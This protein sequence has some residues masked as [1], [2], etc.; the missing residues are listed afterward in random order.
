[1]KIAIV[2]SDFTSAGGIERV[3]TNLSN[4]LVENKYDLTIISLFKTN[5]NAVYQLDS[6]VKLHYLTNKNYLTNKIGGINRLLLYLKTVNK[7]KYFVKEEK[8]DFIIGQGFPINF[9]IFLAGLSNK[10]IACEHVHYNYYSSTIQKVRLFIYQKFSQVVVL[11]D[12][13]KLDF[14]SKGLINITMIPNIVVFEAEMS[15]LSNKIIISVGR[16]EYQKG[17]DILLKSVKE[18]FKKYPDWRLHIYG[19][20]LLERDLK[21]LLTNLELTNNVKF[22]GVT[23]NIKDAYSKASL[24]VMS[25]RFEG[26]GMVLVEAASCGLP[27]I[28][29]D[30]PNG[31]SDILKNN[32][33]ILVPNGDIDML[34][35]E[36]MEML[37]HPEKRKE[38]SSRS[39]EISFE[40]SPKQI[41]S[42]WK[43][44][45]L[46]IKSDVK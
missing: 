16:L 21:T 19:Q 22:M 41:F 32:R 28:S 35:S 9:S 30:C 38:Y 13:D 2:L 17:Y 43:K 8:F 12:K 18:V 33:G 24:F 37:D 46:K 42:Y 14:T 23:N 40:Y 29:F 36:I 11:T 31:P 3:T 45:F 20:G 7:L 39:L 15:N 26:F 1:M 6:K 25:S 4:V 34:S 44:L 10:S 27:I 5:N